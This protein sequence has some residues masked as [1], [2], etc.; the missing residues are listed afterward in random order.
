[1]DVFVLYSCV[2]NCVS[3]SVFV[4]IGVFCVIRVV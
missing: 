1:M 2:C 4:R 3:E